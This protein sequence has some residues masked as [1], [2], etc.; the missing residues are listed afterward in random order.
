V[1]GV[2]QIPG[3]PPGELS[4]E[5]QKRRRRRSI[6]IALTLGVWIVLPLLVTL[7]LAT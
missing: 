1:G 2:T 6:A 5:H 3:R 7:S 4:P